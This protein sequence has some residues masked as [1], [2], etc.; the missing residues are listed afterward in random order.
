[1]R[2]FITL[3]LLSTSL[4]LSAQV[5]STFEVEI[6]NDGIVLPRVVKSDKMMMNPVEG[7]LIYNP[8]DKALMYYDGAHWMR[9]TGQVTTSDL[10]GNIYGTVEIGGL[11]WMTSDLR[12]TQ[13][14]DG[15]PLTVGGTGSLTQ[16]KENTKSAGGVPTLWYYNNDAA[17]HAASYGGLYN[18]CA[19]ETGNLCPTG[20]RVPTGADWNSLFSAAGG[21]SVA[22]GHM[23]EIG[24]THW[25]FPNAGATNLTGF[26]ARGGGLYNDGI[27]LGLKDRA[28]YW[29]SDQSNALIAIYRFINASDGA[30]YSE[31]FDKNST[32][33]SVRCVR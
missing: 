7:Q 32:G 33:I 31:G 17:T 6:N 5:T 18:F 10:D 30:V 26:T 13:L 1:M 29:Q 25:N 3:L 11:E 27:F 4:I 15:T 14:N 21:E 22:G 19:V 28:L 12:V 9:L 23:K 24:L 16:P 2:N 20:W 8:D